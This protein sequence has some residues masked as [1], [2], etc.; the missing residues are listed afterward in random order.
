MHDRKHGNRKQARKFE[1]VLEGLSS[2][3]SPRNMHDRKHGNRKQSRN[4]DIVPACQNMKWP[5]CTPN[6]PAV[7][8]P[9]DYLDP[10]G[11]EI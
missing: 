1:I 3:V 11:S 7:P 9:V 2:S 5:A 8:V 4:F 6:G 10:R